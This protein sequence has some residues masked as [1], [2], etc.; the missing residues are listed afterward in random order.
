MPERWRKVSMSIA[1]ILIS[2]LSIPQGMAWG[3]LTHYSI[4]KDAGMNLTEE[5]SASVAPDALI[6]FNYGNNFLDTFV[7]L[8]IP[9]VLYGP[10]DYY[11]YTYS[12]PQEQ[13]AT[14][15]M[16]HT[17]SDRSSHGTFFEN[18]PYPDSNNYLSSVGADTLREHLKAEFGGDI[19]SYWLNQGTTP[20][21]IV[22]H[23]EQMRTALS[24][25]DASCKSNYSQK[26]DQERFLM[27]FESLQAVIYAEQLLID[28]QQDK[29]AQLTDRAFLIWAY[30]KYNESY[31]KYYPKSVDNVKAASRP[32]TLQ[33]CRILSEPGKADSVSTKIKID[34]GRELIHNGLIKTNKKFDENKG[35]ISMNLE[36]NVSGQELARAY[37]Q[38]LE[39]VYEK[40]TG[41]KLNIQDEISS[42]GVFITP[43]EIKK[44]YPELYEKLIE[45]G[46][47]NE[48]VP[49]IEYILSF[50]RRYLV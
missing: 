38:Y 41:E 19:L 10:L 18:S 29:E 24:N 31:K 27:A 25:Y 11:M 50:F 39:K 22:I 1:M 12:E 40:E 6:D 21:E 13:W 9:N 46:A 17:I 28:Y 5:I 33:Q 36:Q 23:T 43:I 37:G 20:G 35:T 26:Y 42:N 7:H 45:K 4:N 44:Y 14:G 8:E 34:V 16:G 3:G 48:D 47:I 15:W 32:Q 2:L 49:L 30:Q